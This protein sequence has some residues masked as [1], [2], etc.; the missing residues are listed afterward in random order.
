MGDASGEE[1][2]GALLIRAL[3]IYDGVVGDPV[4]HGA[5]AA[6]LVRAARA[7]GHAEATVVALRAVAW[8]E[9]S[10]MRNAEALRL[11]NEAARRAE[12]A[13]LDHRHGEVLVT[14]AAV[15]MELGRIGAALR[16]LADAGSL[17]DVAAVPDLELKRSVLL[18]NSGLLVG[19]AEGYRRVLADP[20]ATVDV[21]ARAANN[22]GLV[23]ALRG[24]FAEALA[25]LDAATELAAQVGAAFVAVVAHNR[26]LVLAQAGRLPES[27]RQ[28]DTALGLARVAGLPLGELLIEHGE[29]LATL[30]VLPEARALAQRAAAELDA[31]EVP[32]MAA[33]AHV[34][35]GEIALLLDDHDAAERAGATAADLLRRQRRAPWAA[36]ATVVEV[37]A[38]HRAG[39]AEAAD[40][41][42]LRRA[43]R[44][45]RH[46]RIPADAVA[47]D[48]ELGR[49]AHE[50]GRPV[51]A[52]RRLAAA[53]ARSRRGTVLIRLRGRLAA[54]EAARMDGDEAAVLRHARAGLADLDRHRAVFAS[55]ELRALAAH[56][57]VELGL[58]GLDVLLRRGRP[59]P[60][61]EWAER[62][63]A[64]ARL[65]SPVAEPDEVREERAALAALHVDLAAARLAGEPE[66]DGIAERERETE[67]RI[68][69]SRWWQGGPAAGS[70][71]RPGLPRLLERL[72]GRVLAS[73]GRHGDTVYCVTVAG[74]RRALV[75]LGS[76]GAARFEIDALLFALRRLTRPGRPAALAA[77]RAAAEHA[78]R[79]LREQLVAPLGLAPA[80]P[81]VVV[82]ARDSHRLPWTALHDG[83][84]SVAPSLALWARTTEAPDPRDLRRRVVVVAGPDLAGAD[85]EADVVAA[86]HPGATVLRP[87][88]S[89]PARVLDAMRGADLVHL[90]CH[91]V[92]R[93]DNPMFS[94][95]ELHEGRITVQ[96]IDTAG[97]TPARL[98]L[99]ACDSGADVGVAG[100]E[101]LGFTS[102]L[103]ARG[104]RGLV[105]SVVA[106]EDVAAV[107]LMDAL[108][109]GLA[110]GLPVAE[111]LHAARAAGDPADHR[112]FVNRCGFGAYGAG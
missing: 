29:T 84:V 60:V 103:L 82:P 54:A 106:V 72:D 14:R 76:W 35:L 88:A 15:Q 67:R 110:A 71:S 45:L 58:M 99:A 26:G 104:T 77:A 43:A 46:S 70:A 38:R 3:A 105:A 90:A 85:I 48:L 37:L 49:L 92:L 95:L 23:H 91:G 96:D 10:R 4:R 17:V 81:L 101:I 79:R 32:L 30:R 50:L 83:P 28:M 25:L 65:G 98:V 86:R 2:D 74:R 112:S 63:R 97:A 73:F 94:A 9:R 55:M 89:T 102:A 11:L 16:D 1:P 36:R 18:H 51:L 75:P 6:A 21:R 66:Q 20:A 42:R 93:A 53:H 39:R 80:A 13:G 31:H 56:H 7:A 62:T 87:P 33:E 19:A 109:E 69:H 41:D 57:G 100:E 8:F 52:R 5:E 12:A 40:L 47:A 64:V 68:R 111:A 24:R 61:L 27:V 22:L 59:T 78:L 107:T 34:R 108:H 44:V